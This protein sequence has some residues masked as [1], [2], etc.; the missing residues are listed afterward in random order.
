MIREKFL[1]CLFNGPLLKA[2]AIAVFLGEDSNERVDVA[3]ELMASGA[4]SELFLTGAI[5][6]PPRQR[7]ASAMTPALLG[8][9]V[10]P[11]AVFA[12]NEAMHTRDQSVNLVAAALERGWKRVLLVASPYHMPRAFLTVLRALTDIGESQNIHVIPVTAAQALWFQCPDG[13][14]EKRVDLWSTEMAKIA[15]Y[16]DHVEDWRTGLDYLR[17][18]EGEMLKPQTGDTSEEHGADD[19]T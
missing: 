3:I 8:R 6:N 7:S 10:S 19:D 4:A 12:D 11:S 15:E 16:A 5:D 2:D 18:W 13:M 17:Y 1:A 9:G 14:T